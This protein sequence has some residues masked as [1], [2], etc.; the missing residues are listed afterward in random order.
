MKR[1]TESRRGWKSDD[2]YMVNG[3]VSLDL[4]K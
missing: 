3:L 2:A 1:S 4:K